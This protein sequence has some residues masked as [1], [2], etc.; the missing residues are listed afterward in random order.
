[1][2]K[3]KKSKELQYVSYEQAQRLK[4]LGFDWE[5]TAMYEE[6]TLT[7][8]VR[9]FNYNSPYWTYSAPNIPLTLKWIRDVKNYC[10]CVVYSPARGRGDYSGYVWCIFV[11][12]WN[13][14]RQTDKTYTLPDNYEESE[15][16]LLDELI[17][18]M[19]QDEVLRLKY[20][21]EENE[22]EMLKRKEEE[23]DEDIKEDEEDENI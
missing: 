6:G 4:K 12:K 1:M 17:L 11:E 21:E 19:E 22:A 2:N 5:C 9:L 13:H 14:V 16:E 10:G 18:I 15:R 3:N 23:E 7:T 20:K 8:N